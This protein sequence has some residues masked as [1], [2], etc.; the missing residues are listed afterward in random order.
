MAFFC[1]IQDSLRCSE[2]LFYLQEA[3]ANRDRASGSQKGFRAKG[4][5][6]ETRGP[7]NWA[8]DL[9]LFSLQY[10]REIQGVAPKVLACNCRLNNSTIMSSR[11]CRGIG[12]R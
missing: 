2:G 8:Y 4:R 1:R 10:F 3:M 9:R 12:I 6:C 5:A 7:C 11:P